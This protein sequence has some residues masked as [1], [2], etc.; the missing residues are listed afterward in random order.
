MF[1]E[2]LSRLDR[3]QQQMLWLVVEGQ[4][5]GDIAERLGISVRT[6]QR[7]LKV[8]REVYNALQT[9]AKHS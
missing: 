6:L 7:H 4:S 1:H 5:Q 9:E 8:V 3:L 2:L